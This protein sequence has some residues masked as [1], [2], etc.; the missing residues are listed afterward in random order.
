VTTAI[1]EVC[2]YAGA[3]C[4]V[5]GTL[6]EK[7][8]YKITVHCEG[9]PEKIQ[10]ARLKKGRFILS[11]NAG[12]KE[13]LPDHEVLQEYKAQAGTEKGFQFIKDNCFECDSLFLKTSRR[14]EV[15]A[16][17]GATIPDQK[18]K[19]TNKPRLKGVYFL[20][21]GVHELRIEKETETREL[22]INVNA[23]LKEII[24]YFGERARRIYLNPA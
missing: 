23:L 12:D 8:G 9:D 4:P 15:L 17:A 21:W 13:K 24:G 16:K 14:R 11:T 18:R 3:G 19:P 22:V 1:E 2:R 20:F 5:T 10:K 6:P 7:R